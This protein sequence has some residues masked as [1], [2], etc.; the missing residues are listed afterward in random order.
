MLILSE[1]LVFK[2]D[3]FDAVDGNLLGDIENLKNGC[4]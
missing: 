3:F 1:G 4:R 2:T